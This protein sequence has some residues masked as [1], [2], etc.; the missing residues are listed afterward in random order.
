MKTL[1]TTLAVLALVCVTSAADAAG[2]DT[3]PN[4][5]VKIIVPFAPGGGSDNIAR[6]ISSRLSERTGKIFIVDNRPGAGTNIGNEQASRAEPDGNTLLFGQ[7]TLSINPHVYKGLKYDVRTDFVPIVQI[8]NSPSV[9]VVTTSLPVRTLG[10]FV[11][12][13]KANPGKLNY[14]SGGTGTSVHLAGESFS[15]LINA[16]MVHV[17]Y[18]GSAPAV[19][20][21]IG[22]QIQ[23]MF[24]TAPSALPH[25][26]GGKV[27]ALAVTG[28]KRL[29]SLPDVPTFAE[30]GRPDFDAPAW[31]GL[32]AP[33]GTSPA[34][35]TYLNTQVNEVLRDPAVQK[36]LRESGAEP[37]GGTAAD[38]TAFIAQE[39]NRW[40]E[41]AS[42]AKVSAE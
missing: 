10:E 41:V 9:L 39:N 25:I 26:K 17:P 6:L 19:T 27:R 14:G 16:K 33:K 21:L 24:D 36:Q 31:Y 23:A 38:F 35:V 12:Y 5:L 32:L 11:D 3:Y 7:V 29:S 30:A 1:Q 40:K 28:N 15:S 8:A 13:A 20:D 37:V 2:T 22:G 42:T 34:V 4:Q 18:R